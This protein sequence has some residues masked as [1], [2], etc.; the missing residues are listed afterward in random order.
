MTAEGHRHIRYSRQVTLQ[1]FSEKGQEKLLNGKLAVIGCGG[2]GATAAVYLAAS[3]VGQIHL[4]DFDKVAYSNLHRQVFYSPQDIGQYKS[5]VLLRYLNRINEDILVTESKKV[6]TKSTIDDELNSYD[7]ILDCTDSLPT[8]YLINDYCVL[9]AKTLVY[10]S[11]Y[12]HDGYIATFNAPYGDAFSANLRDAFPE[13]P[14]GHVPNC[15]EIGTLNPIVGIIAILQANEA[16]KFLSGTGQILKNE[17]MIIN[18]MEN[19]RFSMKIKPSFSVD[20][21]KDIFSSFDYQDPSCTIQNEEWLIRKDPLI[22]QLA[23]NKVEIL[24]VIEQ[25]PES[26]P[27]KIDHQIPLSQF[28]PKKFEWNRSKTLVVICQRGVSSYRA[29]ETLKEQFPAARILSLQSGIQQFN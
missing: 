20:K 12:K 2:L 11:L 24:S 29:V 9:H 5:E 3:G 26:Y 14:K 6:L 18:S 4:I 16:I 25:E 22:D 27:F 1:D 23:N 13:I 8:K 7:L 28:D 15:S 17:V 19:T 21:I 10:G